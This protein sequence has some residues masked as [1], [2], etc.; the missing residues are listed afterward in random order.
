MF[1]RQGNKDA[2][3][4]KRGRGK[5]SVGKKYLTKCRQNVIFRF[6]TNTILDKGKLSK[7]THALQ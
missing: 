3:V 5:Y 1:W 2:K 4:E 7:H 6:D